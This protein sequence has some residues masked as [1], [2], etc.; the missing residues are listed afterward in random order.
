MLSIGKM[1]V[2]RVACTALFIAQ[3]RFRLL[4]LFFNVFLSSLFVL[5]LFSSF[6]MHSFENYI[7]FSFL[8]LTAVALGQFSDWRCLSKEEEKKKN[9]ENGVSGRTRSRRDYITEN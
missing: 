6:F 8:V 9:R 2:M 7:Y 1:I 4:R 3:G 5:L